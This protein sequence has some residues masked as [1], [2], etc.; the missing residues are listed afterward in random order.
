MIS[1][2][3]HKK[4][5]SAAGEMLLEV[6]LKLEEKKM[7][8]IYGASGAG[9]TSLLRIL[10]G[11]LKPDKGQIVVDG[12]TW[13]DTDKS[14]CV[15]PQK[16]NVG[17]VF[18]DYALFP[19]MTVND[20]LS[21]ALDKGGDKKIIKELME[22]MELGGLKDHKPDMLSGGQKQRTALARALVQKPKLLL[23]DEPLAALD[24]NMRVKLQGY[25]LKV[26][27]EYKL[28]T[29]LVSHD[30]AEI[31]KMSDQILMMEH[32]KIINQGSP[33]KVFTHSEM[34]GKFQFTGEVMAMDK[35]DFIFIVTIL[36]GK[37]LVKVIVEEDE[38]RRLMIGDKVLVAAKAF[39]P[40]IR[41]IE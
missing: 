4:L 7:V 32:G 10:A 26:H 28:T 12:T 29:I 23:L 24:H 1:L 34:S 25:I 38:A 11:L 40:V 27:R 18:Q 33:E 2:S 3:L 21:F 17:L 37:D 14:I 13:L 5:R 39:N 20:N 35:Q 36:I 19:H 9:K 31:L 15:T 8:T 22:I 6:E 30:I 41:K 16:R